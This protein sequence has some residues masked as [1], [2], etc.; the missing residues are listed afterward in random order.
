MFRS[1]LQKRL[2]E[3]F[4]V[5][6]T[7]LLAPDYE[8]PE[9]DTLFVEI[10][11]TKT[12]PHGKDRCACKTSGRLVMFS[13]AERITFGFFSK[14]IERATAEA[15]DGL[16]FGPEFDVPDSPA[17]RQNLHERQ[18]PFTFLFDTQYDPDRGELESMN[19]SLEMES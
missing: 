11:E 9:Q 6:K 12:R 7:T 19:T 4:G 3:I 16:F 8:A 1:E 10:A 18:V 13:Q 5:K 2:K 14:A 15:K 17:R